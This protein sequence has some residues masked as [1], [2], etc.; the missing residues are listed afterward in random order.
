MRDQVPYALLCILHVQCIPIIVH[1]AYD[2][3]KLSFIII[4]IIASGNKNVTKNIQWLNVV[5]DYA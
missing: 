3:T 1:V 2:A 5:V 4:I